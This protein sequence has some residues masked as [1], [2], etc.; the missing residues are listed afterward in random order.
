MQSIKELEMS[1]S[2][3]LGSKDKPKKEV[4]K[5]MNREIPKLH[6]FLMGNIRNLNYRKR[7]LVKRAIHTGKVPSFLARYSGEFYAYRIYYKEVEGLKGRGDY[8]S[9]PTP[10]EKRGVIRYISTVILFLYRKW[11]A[12]LFFKA[13][14]AAGG[15]EELESV[16]LDLYSVKDN[17]PYGYAYAK[18]I[19]AILE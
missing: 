9:E 10:E 8:I 15:L 3:R 5:V 11:A 16:K 14:R 18:I 4:V 19:D 17:T 7:E 2:Q 1:D 12:K 13:H 6:D